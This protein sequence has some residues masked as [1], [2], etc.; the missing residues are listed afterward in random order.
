MAEEIEFLGKNLIEGINAKSWRKYGNGTLQIIP[1]AFNEQDGIC[2]KDLASGKSGIVVSPF[3]PV[4]PGY[5][6]IS[7]SYKSKGFGKK[8]YSGVSSYPSVTWYNAK[9]QPIKSLEALWRFEYFDMDWDIVDSVLCCPPDAAFMNLRIV[10]GNGSPLK[11]GKTQAPEVTFS[12]IQVRR[13]TPPSAPKKL[14]EKTYPVRTNFPFKKPFNLLAGGKLAADKETKTG[15]TMEM[16][17]TGKKQLTSH[18]QYE[19]NWLPG[20]YR[21]QVKVKRGKCDKSENLGSTDVLSQNDAG[22]IVMH[23]DTDNVKPA[24]KYVTLERDFIVHSPGFNVLRVISTGKVPWSIAWIKV[25]PLESLN[26]KQLKAMYP[27]P[28]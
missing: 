6:F 15:S 17:A 18:G 3:I 27:Q 26:E 25:V 1:K 23:F 7:L 13:Y 16:P 12:N 14:D 22:R 19:T 20:L 28:E 9:K 8:G 11:D 24:G 4:A 21:L 2:V 10:L 5:Y